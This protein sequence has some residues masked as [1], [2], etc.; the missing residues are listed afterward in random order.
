M[1]VTGRQRASNG[2]GAVLAEHAGAQLLARTQDV[3]LHRGR[4]PIAGTSG[5][6]ISE[7]HTI[8]SL[9]PSTS[10]PKGNGPCAH[11]EL[12]CNSLEARGNDG[13]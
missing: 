7:V 8:Q 13:P 2:L 4:Q 5:L 10:Y 12:V 9:I 11:T 3:P 1:G 6:A